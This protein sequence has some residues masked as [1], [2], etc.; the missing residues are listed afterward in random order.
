M[1]DAYKRDPCPVVLPISKQ[2]CSMAKGH[3]GPH[4]LGSPYH[5]TERFVT[6][7]SGNKKCEYHRNSATDYTPYPPMQ[8]EWLECIFCGHLFFDI[9]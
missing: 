7:C 2:L 1:K 6:Q 4:V 8:N 3:F 5:P 9:K